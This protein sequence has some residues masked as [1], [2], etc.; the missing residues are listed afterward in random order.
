MNL[1]V[2]A[3]GTPAAC[4]PEPRQTP[5]ATAFGHEVAQTVASRSA[6]PVSTAASTAQTVALQMPGKDLSRWPCQLLELVLCHLE[7]LDLARAS[8]T[9][10]RWYQTASSHKL[11][12]GSFIK[13]CRPHHHS[14]GQQTLNLEPG[15]QFLSLWSQQRPVG[16]ARREELEWLAGQHLSPLALCCALTRELLRATRI[17]SHPGN[18]SILCSLNAPDSMAFSPDGS[19]LVT[20]NHNLHMRAADRLSIWRQGPGGLHRATW[21]PVDNGLARHSLSFSPDS[22]RLLCVTETGQLLTWHQQADGDWQSVAPRQLCPGPVRMATFSPDAH[23]LALRVGSHVLLCTETEPDAWQQCFSLEWANSRFADRIT[24]FGPDNAQFS[25]D[26][27]HFLFLNT[28]TAFVF[29]RYG[30]DWQAQP[31]GQNDLHPFYEVGALS[32]AGDWL[33]ITSQSANFARSPGYILE[34][35][36]YQHADRN[37][38]FS[39]DRSFVCTGFN[40]PL[41][42]RPDGRQLVVPDRLDNGDVCVSVLSLTP[43]AHWELNFQLPFG[44]GLAGPALLSGVYAV[45]F[46][47]NG[48][49]LAATARAGVQIWQ[50]RSG[51]WQPAAWI[52]NPDEEARS[53]PC[54]ALSPDGFHCAVST[55]DLGCVSLHGPASPGG[56]RSRLQTSLGDPVNYLRFAPDGIRLLVSCRYRRHFYNRV[57]LLQLSPA[58]T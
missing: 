12:L 32:P 14:P 42:F 17:L 48:R 47:A 33:A 25:N 3:T 4:S 9:C 31:L 1:P 7:T 24:L 34:L 41:A 44:P 21:C 39:S 19:H 55:G 40:C 38:R 5:A 16:S 51:L 49:C 13:A 53:D 20:Q 35:W 28:G 11:Q 56:Y 2:T 6:S 58:P 50:C 57:S 30:T 27:R 15:R 22:R 54:C 29:D 26:S 18:L 52:E 46:S 37:W 45:S 23:H 8:R 36:R 43:G 10:R